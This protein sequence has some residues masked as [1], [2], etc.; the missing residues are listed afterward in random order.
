MP[1]QSN[2]SAPGEVEA[3]PVGANGLDTKA[4]ALSTADA[5]RL[6]AERFRFVIRYVQLTSPTPNEPPDPTHLTL[7]EATNI[8]QGGLGVMA[9]QGHPLG[10]GPQESW[11]P[12]P[13]S[14]VTRGN[15]AVARAQAS[16]LD[17]G[18]SV[19]LDIENIVP[20]TLAAVVMEYCS[21]WAGIVRN[22]GYSPGLYVGAGA[23][24]NATQLDALNFDVYWA[25]PSQA[26]PLPTHGYAITQSLPFNQTSQLGSGK[27]IDVDH[28]QATNNGAT[29]KFQ[30]LAI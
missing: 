14:A 21:S 27:P 18:V 3:L 26:P 16:G 15:A 30:R 24:L 9:V 6:Y 23:Q 11:L 10:S 5:I 19:F 17:A 2:V 8:I 12:D 28:S 22:G 20:G 7:T 13:V 29:A 25:A 4:F 1:V